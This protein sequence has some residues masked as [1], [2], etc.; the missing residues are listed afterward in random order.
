MKSVHKMVM[1]FLL[2]VVQTSVLNAITIDENGL[3]TVTENCKK[4]ARVGGNADCGSILKEPDRVHG[5][6]YSVNRQREYQKRLEEAKFSTLHETDSKLIFKQVDKSVLNTYNKYVM[7]YQS[8]RD[9]S[10]EYKVNIVLQYGNPG[11]QRESY[12][13]LF[14]AYTTSGAYEKAQE[15]ID[16]YNLQGNKSTKIRRMLYRIMEDC[17][18]PEGFFVE[19]IYI[20]IGNTIIWEREVYRA[21]L[22]FLRL[23]EETSGGSR[24]ANYYH[25]QGWRLEPSQTKIVECIKPKGFWLCLCP[26]S[27]WADPE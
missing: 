20:E 7:P 17:G 11:L 10:S 27:I 2:I 12:G 9:S 18:W 8:T 24:V 15:W 4:L 14:E 23:I 3:T 5:K 26:S 16:E 1:V 13:L 6:L 22:P 25:Q 19:K 21:E